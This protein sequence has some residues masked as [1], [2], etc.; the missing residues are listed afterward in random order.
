M[1]TAKV[2]IVLL[3]L[4][5]MLTTSTIWVSAGTDQ[6]S[7]TAELGTGLLRLATALSWTVLVLL[8]VGDRI[9]RKIEAARAEA[10]R[11]IARLAQRWG[12]QLLAAELEARLGRAAEGSSSSITWLKDRRLKDRRTK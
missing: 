5:V 11:E 12:D 8:W 2:M 10:M 1:T 4:S 6:P 3:V 9:I 7:D